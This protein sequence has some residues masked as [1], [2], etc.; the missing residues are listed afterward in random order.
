[1]LR[2]ATANVPLGRY[3]AAVTAVGKTSLWTSFG[4]FAPS[5][6]S[7]PGSQEQGCQQSPVYNS[8]H[9]FCQDGPSLSSAYCVATQPSA[10]TLDRLTRMAQDR[11]LHAICLLDLACLEYT[12]SQ[13]TECPSL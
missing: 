13:K 4:S 10:L 12:V 8:D 3:A 11:K 5:L 6:R 2:R 1:M 9:Q 7:S